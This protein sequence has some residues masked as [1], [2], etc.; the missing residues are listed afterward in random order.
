MTPAFHADVID[1]CKSSGVPAPMVTLPFVGGA[2]CGQGT[3]G[4][5]Q[6]VLQMS[7]SCICDNH[8]RAVGDETKWEACQWHGH[9]VF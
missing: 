1:A 5:I 7:L 4:G 2:I 8:W 9:H 6:N 3:L